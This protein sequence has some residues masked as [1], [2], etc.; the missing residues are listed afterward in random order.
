MKTYT[1]QARLGTDSNLVA[2]LVV[3]KVLVERAPLVFLL[4]SS[5]L[6]LTIIQRLPSQR[7][8]NGAG[9]TTLHR[10]YSI[11]LGLIR[12]LAV[13]TTCETPTGK[14][15][16]VDSFISRER[17]QLIV[18]SGGQSRTLLNDTGDVS[19]VVRLRCRAC[20][21]VEGGAAA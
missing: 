3:R 9:V 15:E 21:D 2:V 4:F 17:R 8:H 19:E 12:N 18:L 14:Y 5:L 13:E 10:E 7:L 11:V 1:L 16:P 6:S 20:R